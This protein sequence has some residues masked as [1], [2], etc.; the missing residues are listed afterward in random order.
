MKKIIIAAC[1][2]AV[3]V[4][5]FAQSGTNSPYSQFGLGLLN[6]QS[7][8]F[9]RG[10]DGVGFGFHDHNQVNVKNPASYS[11]LDSLTFIFDAAVGFQVTNF[12]ENGIKKNAKNA[13]FEYAVGAFRAARHVGVAFGVLPYSNVGYNY[14]NTANVNA[15]NSTQSVNPTYSNTYSG[16][17]G[18]HEVFVGVGWQPV[19]NFSFGANAGY[20][21]GDIDRSVVNSY[22]DSY[23]NTLSKYYKMKVKGYRLTFG[24]Q[25]TLPMGKKDAV[26]LGVV[27][28][29]G[30]KTHTD[31]EC[32]VVSSNS[33]TSVNDTALYSIKNGISIPDRFGAG[34]MW[35]HLNRLK[36]GFD[37]QLEK[38]GSIGMP[39]Y[40]VINNVAS[41]S[42]VGG[43]MKDRS[44]FTLGGDY[45]RGERYRSLFSRIHYRAG[46]SY[47][48]S[49]QTIN[50][51]DGPKEVSASV[52]FGI[53][54]INTYNNRSIL[55]ITASWINRSATNLIKENTFMFTLGL[56]FNERWFAKF[57]VE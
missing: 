41:Y 39:Q 22:S 20:L 11:A 10:M 18:A 53:P 8:G 3:S 38:W 45:C 28:E 43:T 26:T 5:V 27:Y 57:K 21:W 42:L 4:S 19:K 54:I 36:I 1:L 47:V 56:T 24:A 16:D 49:Y 17:G 14:S 2:L 25:Y 29:P 52:G 13:D 9:N 30:H 15:F 35:S 33:Q 12:N 48:P 31:P 50:G 46:L 7:T 32:L 44:R 40:Q 6:D 34:L 51:V 55:N 23:V 37:Y